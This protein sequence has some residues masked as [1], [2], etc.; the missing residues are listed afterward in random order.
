LTPYNVKPQENFIVIQEYEDIRSK[1]VDQKLI[2]AIKI[3]GLAMQLAEQEIALS[4]KPLKSKIKIKKLQERKNLKSV[5]LSKNPNS[6]F[7]FIKNSQIAD[8]MKSNSL[9]SV[10]EEKSSRRLLDVEPNLDIGARLV[11]SGY[12]GE[13][14]FKQDM[15]TIKSPGNIDN[16][17]AEKIKTEESQ[18]IKED[19]FDEDFEEL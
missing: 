5:W 11:N 19:E 1:L 4:Q 18:I 3:K 12:M 14:T 9:E 16:L 6:K 7:G 10:K 8:I 2:K 13:S 15:D 17:K